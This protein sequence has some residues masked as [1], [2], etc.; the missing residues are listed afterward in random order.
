M[1]D[2]KNFRK[3]GRPYASDKL[4]KTDVNFKLLGKLKAW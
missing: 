4:V 1:T 3:T 2:N